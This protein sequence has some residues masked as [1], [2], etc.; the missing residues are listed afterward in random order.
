MVRRQEVVG[1]DADSE[2]EDFARLGGTKFFGD[3]RVYV[4]GVCGRNSSSEEGPVFD[5]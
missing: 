4:P 3:E 2:V 1:P 5:V